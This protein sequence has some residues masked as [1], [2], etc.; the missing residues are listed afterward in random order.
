MLPSAISSY[1]CQSGPVSQTLPDAHNLD[2]WEDD[3]QPLRLDGSSV[4]MELDSGHTF[5]AAAPKEVRLCSVQRV[6]A[7]GAVRTQPD[8]AE[9]PSDH[10]LCQRDV[11]QPFLL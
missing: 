10:M 5:L 7:G 2:T 9:V 6:L 4:S 1:G 3:R 11:L 8:N